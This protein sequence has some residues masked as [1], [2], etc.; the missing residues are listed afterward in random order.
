MIDMQVNDLHRKVVDPLSMILKLLAI[1]NSRHFIALLSSNSVNKILGKQLK[2]ALEKQF[3]VPESHVYLLLVSFNDCKI[4]EEIEYV[5]LFDPDWEKR[6][7]R[8]LQA[9]ATGDSKL[10]KK[11]RDKKYFT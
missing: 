1:K 6:I 2:Y 9:I 11:T 8:I 7:K 4:P 5:D 3:E 10:S